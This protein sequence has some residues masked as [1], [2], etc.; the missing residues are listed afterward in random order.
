MTKSDASI[1]ICGLL[2]NI[3]KR[4]LYFNLYANITISKINIYYDLSITHFDQ[5]FL[6]IMYESKIDMIINGHKN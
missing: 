6:L 5:R 2:N 4:I 1:M 3:L